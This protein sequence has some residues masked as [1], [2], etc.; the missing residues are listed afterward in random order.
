V[1]IFLIIVSF[2]SGLLYFLIFSYFD[3]IIG[4]IN[5]TLLPAGLQSF[6]KILVLL[7]AGFCIGLIPML[8]LAPGMKRSRLDIR[9]LILMGI[10]PF[11]LLILSPGPV[12]DF[13]ATRI[14]SNN[15]QIRE[16]LFYL[17]SR[18]PLWSVW[19]GFAIGTSTR[20][21]FKKKEHRHVVSN[22]AGEDER[23]NKSRDESN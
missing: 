21:S 9:N 14:F 20:I 7:I 12:I 23:L 19:L 10:V 18:Q 22:D 1:R 2:A 4:V 13:L 16:L 5:P 17:F 3:T 6:I 11:I 15:E 8:L